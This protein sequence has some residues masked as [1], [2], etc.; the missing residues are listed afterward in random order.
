VPTLSGGHEHDDHDLVNHDHG[1]DEDGVNT[2]V[3]LIPPTVPPQ[4]TILIDSPLPPPYLLRTI[5]MV[6]NRSI[7]MVMMMIMVSS[8]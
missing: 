4:P 1:R 6:V 2:I 3:M 7:N 8:T 5:V